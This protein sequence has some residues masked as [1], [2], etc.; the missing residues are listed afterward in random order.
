MRHRL[1]IIL[2]IAGLICNIVATALAAAAIYVNQT[3]ANT[4]ATTTWGSND[5]FKEALLAQSKYAILCVMALSFGTA[6]QMAAEL[7]RDQRR[8]HDHAVAPAAARV[9]QPAP[10]EEPEHHRNR[11]HHHRH[12]DTD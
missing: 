6:L 8:P 4:L 2:S 3:T 9:P 1:R 7:V 11:H 5:F 10:A 12:H